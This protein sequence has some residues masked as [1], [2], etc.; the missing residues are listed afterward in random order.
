MTLREKISLMKCDCS[1]IFIRCVEISSNK[2]AARINN[3]VFIK[4]FNKGG[5]S[6]LNYRQPGLLQGGGQR[7]IGRTFDNNALRQGDIAN[8]I[9]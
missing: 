7:G 3:R 2:Y 4:S 6:S 9:L 1:R 5:Y 8:G